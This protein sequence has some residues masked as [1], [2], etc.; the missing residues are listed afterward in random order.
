I[1]SSQ[2]I[3]SMQTPTFSDARAKTIVRRSSGQ[4]DLQTLDRIQ[5]TDFRWID[6][7]KGNTGIHKKVIAQE[8]EEVLPNAVSRV[9][10]LIP[11]IYQQAASMSYDA[12]QHR[13][14]VSINKAHNLQ[15]GDQVDVYTDRG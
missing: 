2:S 12:K 15:T 10:K 1:V 5:I 3:F 11:N 7:T 8:V 4:E 9:T 14:T 13:L 6:Q